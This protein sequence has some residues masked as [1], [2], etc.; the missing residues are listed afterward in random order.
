M[1][2]TKKQKREF[3]SP[4]SNNNLFHWYLR[5]NGFRERSRHSLVAARCGNKLNVKIEYSYQRPFDDC[6]HFNVNDRMRAH[7]TSLWILDTD[8]AAWHRNNEPQAACAMTEAYLRSRSTIAWHS[9]F[10]SLSFFHILLMAVW[11]HSV[12]LSIGHQHRCSHTVH[13]H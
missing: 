2:W 8:A 1:S 11:L 5:W 13:W 7:T 9:I 10:V 3:R 6:S 12:W 4:P